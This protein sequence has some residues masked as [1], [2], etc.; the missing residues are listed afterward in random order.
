VDYQGDA[1]IMIHSN[2]IPGKGFAAALS[3]DEIADRLAIVA[4]KKE[5]VGGRGLTDQEL[6]ELVDPVDCKRSRSRSRGARV[7]QERLS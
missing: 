4:A 6:D 1:K 3:N 7:R 5:Q 2:V